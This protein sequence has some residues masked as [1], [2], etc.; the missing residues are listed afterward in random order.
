MGTNETKFSVGDQFYTHKERSDGSK[1]L[2][3]GT[4]GSET[5]GKVVINPNETIGYVRRSDGSLVADDKK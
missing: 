1:V 2:I 5:H 4:K 3:Y